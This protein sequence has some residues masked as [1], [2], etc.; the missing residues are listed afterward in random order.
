MVAPAG[1]GS[2]SRMKRELQ[3]LGKLLGALVVVALAFVV[4]ANLTVGFEGPVDSKRLAASSDALAA[5]RPD[6]DS[7][8]TAAGTVDQ[9]T[10]LEATC[11]MGDSVPI[12]PSLRR[13]W[14]VRPEADLLAASRR[15]LT[16]LVERGW[17]AAGNP[18]GTSMRLTKTVNG[19]LL[20]ALIEA[21]EYDGDRTLSIHLV[22]D[23]PDGCAS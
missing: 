12:G 23:G 4:L 1:S 7:V 18:D 22:V 8:H 13:V 21:P 6:L 14:T 10:G 20:V 15:V 5:A 17:T 3:E 9:G 19:H 2:S 11:R 16:D